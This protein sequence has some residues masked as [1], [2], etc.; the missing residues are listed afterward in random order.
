MGKRAKG[1]FYKVGIIPV[2]VTVFD[3]RRDVR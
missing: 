2:E 1:D 3:S